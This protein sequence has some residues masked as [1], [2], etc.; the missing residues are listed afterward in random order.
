LDER[1]EADSPVAAAQPAPVS[2]IAYWAAQRYF[3]CAAPASVRASE[4][5]I[6][7]RRNAEVIAGQLISACLWW[8][9]M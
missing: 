4:P 7:D 6:F 3:I 2:T 5:W 1:E 8:R 9:G